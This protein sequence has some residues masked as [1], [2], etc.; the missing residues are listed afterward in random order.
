MLSTASRSETAYPTREAWLAA[1]RDG[2]GSSDAAAIIG[3]SPW[4]SSFQL[5][6]EKLGLADESPEET[7]AMRWGRLL[8][9]PIAEQYVLETGR[10]LASPGPYTIRVAPG[11][12]W[13]LATL[14]RVITEAGARVTP[15]PLEIKTAGAA[16]RND[17]KDEPPLQYQVQVQH[18]LAV[19]GAPWASIV[20]LIGGQ[21]LLWCDV[22]RDERFIA[23][24]LEQEEAFWRRVQRQEP[25]APDASDRTRKFLAE[26]YPRETAGKVIELPAEILDWD[27]QREHAIARL[28]EYGRIKDEAD[29]NIRLALGDAEAGTL[30]D[31][32]IYTYKVQERTGYS[33][34]PSTV[35]VLRRKEAR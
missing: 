20:V 35:R 21:R 16:Q 19:T 33:V 22:E 25:P 8:E 2:I 24:L 9:S 5:Y 17:W 3:V 27:R 13:Q 26:L 11:R 10:R 34:E 15:A 28:Q 14:D 7:E 29:A 6:C 31:G 18:Q 12:P 23:V 32:T 4:K 30:P 1:R